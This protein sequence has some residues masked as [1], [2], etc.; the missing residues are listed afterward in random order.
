MDVSGRMAEAMPSAGLAGWNQ[1]W[2][3][4]RRAQPH[5]ETM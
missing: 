2:Q 5:M 4:H 1:A 3:Q